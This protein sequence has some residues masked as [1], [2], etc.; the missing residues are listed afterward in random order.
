MAGRPDT[1]APGCDPAL[2]PP[3]QTA[4]PPECGQGHSEA[5]PFH[6]ESSTAVFREDLVER[7]D[8]RVQKFP[9]HVKISSGWFDL[10]PGLVPWRDALTDA[11]PAECRQPYHPLATVAQASGQKAAFAHG[12]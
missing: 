2:P 7:T 1:G 8:S 11:S 10:P 5:V 12:P 6:R 9:P 3:C 4:A